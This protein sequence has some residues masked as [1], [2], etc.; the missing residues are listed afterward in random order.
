MITKPTNE[1]PTL[2]QNTPELDS[3]STD[4]RPPATLP[5]APPQESVREEKL[6]LIQVE[7][8]PEEQELLELGPKFALSR[9]VD[10][11]LMDS[12][13]VEIAACAYRMRWVEHLK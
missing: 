7:L 11:K 4:P 9:R 13:R 12:I 1:R 2:T 10:E 8:T 6:T 5:P 3:S